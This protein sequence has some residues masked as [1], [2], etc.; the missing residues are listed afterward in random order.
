MKT[1]LIL[2]VCFAIAHTRYIDSGSS[3]I[4]TVDH[5]ASASVRLSSA[6]RTKRSIA[7]VK[8]C[9]TNFIRVYFICL[10]IEITK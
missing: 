4:L 3:A 7:I 9:P 6:V 2:V 8:K 5:D 10:H 1:I